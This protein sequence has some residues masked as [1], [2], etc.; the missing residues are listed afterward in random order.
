MWGIL[1]S[2]V[3]FLL[4]FLLR[5]AVVAFVLFTGLFVLISEMVP[6]IQNAGLLP[7]TAG[8][9]ESLGSLGSGVWYV[10]DWT[11]FTF[12][13]PLCISAHAARFIIRRIPFFG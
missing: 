5:K 9:N 8:L 13:A 12:G 10:L 11:C 7:T 2:A 4:G 1:F 3:N 6:V